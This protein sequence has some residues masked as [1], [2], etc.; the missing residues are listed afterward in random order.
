MALNDRTGGH[1][2]FREP[3]RDP[4]RPMPLDFDTYSRRVLTEWHA[5]LEREP[6]ETE[7]QRFLEHHPAMVP[8]GSGDIGPGGH[9]QSEL[10]AV[11]RLPELKGAGRSF[12]PDF[13]WVTR[14]TSLITPILIEIEKPTKRW[15][16]K[17][18]KPTRHFHDA[19]GQL[20]DW[21]MW[22]GHPENRTIF[23][24]QFLFHAKYAGRALQP[25]FVLIYG[26]R[27]EFE[28]GGPHRDPTSIGLKRESL[29]QAD[30]TFMTFDSLTPQFKHRSSMTVTW[31][32]KGGPVP[33][34]LSP[35]FC[36]DSNFGRDALVLAEPNDA[37]ARTEMMSDERK[38]YLTARWKFWAEDE[39]RER[40]ERTASGFSLGYE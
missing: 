5:L 2:R 20:A 18:G 28:P 16:R 21:R 13:M 10:S 12:A 7:V 40:A 29:R 9:H 4:D 34:A 25:C 19:H 33:Y 11:F 26:R 1:F 17:D 23:R 15:F 8:G 30:E 38:G 22:F 32:A 24:D 14:S 27:S 36:T 35:L 39:R 3:D 6:E 37:F 31:T